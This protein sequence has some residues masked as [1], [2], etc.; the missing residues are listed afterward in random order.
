ML[1]DILISEDKGNVMNKNRFTEDFTGHEIVM[2]KK[3][4][5]T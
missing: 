1:I 3:E 4:S 2:P 5:K